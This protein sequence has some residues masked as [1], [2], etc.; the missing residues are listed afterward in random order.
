LREDRRADEGRVDYLK[1]D[2]IVDLKSIGNQRD[3]SIEQAIRFEISRLSLQLSAGRLLRGRRRGAQARAQTVGKGT[4][5]KQAPF[6]K[7]EGAA[8]VME[9]ARDR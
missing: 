5:W 2:E 9:W 7:V 8:P 1:I 3:R 6:V 4:V